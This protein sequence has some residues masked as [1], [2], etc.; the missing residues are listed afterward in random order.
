[1]HHSSWLTAFAEVLA[2]EAVCVDLYEHGR[3]VPGK[4]STSRAVGT[5]C[6]MFGMQDS[7]CVL[8]LVL[9]YLSFIVM[10]SF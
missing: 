7:A 8:S 3:L 9:V 1:M 5:R 2:E 4:C 10:A 6:M